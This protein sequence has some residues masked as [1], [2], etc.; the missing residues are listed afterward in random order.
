MYRRLSIPNRAR[1]NL[2]LGMVAF[3][4]S[5]AGSVLLHIV[6]ATNIYQETNSG[7]LTSFFISLQYLPAIVVIFFKSDWEDGVD[8]RKRWLSLELIGALLTLPILLFIDVPNYYVL[9]ILLFARGLVDHVARIIK[10]ISA[11]YI[12]PENRVTQYAPIL[13]AGYHIG[14]ALA[15][16]IGI[17]SG[18]HFSLQTVVQLDIASFVI[19]AG[20]LY[21]I[22]T[23][24]HFAEKKPAIESFFTRISQYRALLLSDDRLC[25]SALLPPVSSAIFQGSY[26]V[27]LPLFPLIILHANS[28]SVAIGYVLTTFAIL[29]GSLFFAYLNKRLDFYKNNYSRTKKIIFG[30]SCMSAVAYVWTTLSDQYVVCALLFTLMVFT[31]EMIWMFGYTGIFAYAPQG[32]LGSVVGISF[33][34]GYCLGSFCIVVAG[35]LLDYFNG[36]FFAVVS[37]FMSA[38]FLLLI[39][40]FVFSNLG[41]KNSI[42]TTQ[43]ET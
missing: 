2:I 18:Q 4:I 14:I 5:A 25:L 27:F 29:S 20:L 19:A 32:E 41:R 6:F 7:L 28:S 1:L 38:Y 3:A 24:N 8:P 43:I 11:R 9:F 33:A 10:S 37:V 35:A 36:H 12:F 13:Q 17:G 22:K 21:F 40:F 30:L 34:F 23:L 15:A 26:S 16:I 39:G 42:Q 31:Y